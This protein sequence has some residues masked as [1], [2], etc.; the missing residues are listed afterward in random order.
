MREAAGGC[1][2]EK[3]GKHSEPMGQPPTQRQ[4]DQKKTERTHHRRPPATAT[5]RVVQPSVAC[6]A[7]VKT[8]YSI[9]TCV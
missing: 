8:H 3:K 2:H 5:Y 4:Q 9:V 7:F 1:S 6:I